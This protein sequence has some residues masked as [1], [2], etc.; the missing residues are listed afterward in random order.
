MQSNDLGNNSC[1]MK[2]FLIFSYHMGKATIN[3]KL[4][5][6]VDVIEQFFADRQFVPLLRR[7]EKIFPKFSYASIHIYWEI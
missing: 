4:N 7:S 3:M 5:K 1:L 6:F 2:L